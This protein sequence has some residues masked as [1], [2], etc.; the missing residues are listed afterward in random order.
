MGTGSLCQLCKRDYFMMNP[1]TYNCG[2][3]NTTSW[4]NCDAQ[5]PTYG[6]CY[7]CPDSRVQYFGDTRCDL[8]YSSLVKEDPV[9][10]YCAKYGNAEG[11]VCTQCQTGYGMV[12]KLKCKSSVLKRLVFGL[13]LVG[14]V[15]L[16]LVIDI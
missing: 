11:T 1:P 12:N 13:A 9:V 4:Y 8:G 7:K 5:G 6:E 15:I 16:G 14:L 3:T 2:T 10:K